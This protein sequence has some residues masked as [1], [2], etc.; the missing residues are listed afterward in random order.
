MKGD[1]KM[2]VC[3]Y[4]GIEIIYNGE[5]D[6][7]EATVKEE[8]IRSNKRSNV[9]KRIAELMETKKDAL[10]ISTYYNRNVRVIKFIRST[11]GGRSVIEED[12]KI[13]KLGRWDSRQLYEFNTEILNKLQ[14]ILKEI[15]LKEKEFDKLT[16]SLIHLKTGKD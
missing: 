3:K 5:D 6:K 4:M 16:E 8:I 11:S 14:K 13:E 9:E 10:L 7:F 2:K 1:K 15:D 12:G